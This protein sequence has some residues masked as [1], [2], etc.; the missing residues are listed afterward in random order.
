[1]AP[2]DGGAFDVTEFGNPDAATVLGAKNAIHAL[3][4]TL[5]LVDRQHGFIQAPLPKVG[6]RGG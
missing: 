3:H 2:Q 1:M 5:G 4:R 6:H